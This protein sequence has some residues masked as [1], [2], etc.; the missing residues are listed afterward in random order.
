MNIDETTLCH[1]VR[2]AAKNLPEGFQVHVHIEKGA[3]WV[4]LDNTSTSFEYSPDG[5]GM[6]LSEQIAECIEKAIMEAKKFAPVA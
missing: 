6:T 2:A 1:T 4:T 3:G 5:A